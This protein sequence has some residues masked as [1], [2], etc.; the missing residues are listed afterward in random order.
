MSSNV[1]LES[2]WMHLR[3][4]P[5]PPNL[6]AEERVCVHM[7]SVSVAIETPHKSG[8][9]RP[10]SFLKRCFLINFFG[11]NNIV[12]IKSGYRLRKCKEKTIS[13]VN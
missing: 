6:L 13:G 9:W 1:Y 10:G 12:T 11:F 3:M 8:S 4:R 7:Q 2:W 5:I